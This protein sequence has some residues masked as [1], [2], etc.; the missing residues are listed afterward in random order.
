MDWPSVPS[1]T[2]TGRTSLT[3]TPSAPARRAVTASSPSPWR[4]ES[5]GWPRC[6]TGGTWPPPP[7]WTAAPSSPTCPSSTTSSVGRLEEDSLAPSPHQPH[8]VRA[9]P[10]P[11]PGP[12]PRH[13]LPSRPGWRAA[14][15]RPPC[16]APPVRQPPAAATPASPPPRPPPD[17]H[18]SPRP[19]T[20]RQALLWSPSKPTQRDQLSPTKKPS[21]MP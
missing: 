18:Q 11:G 5:W 13:H 20:R 8:L 21:S 3:S 14:S 7:V 19:A 4:S 10:P 2:V 9:V 1:S 6:S 12:G 16:P 15:S 17:W